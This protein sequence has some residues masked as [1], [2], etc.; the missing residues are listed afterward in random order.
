VAAALLAA[1]CGAADPDPQASEASSDAAALA[2]STATT[3]PLTFSSTTTEGEDFDAA[4]LAGEDVVLWFW[5]PWCTIC[6]S[7]APQVAAAAE[8]VDGVTVIGV[9]SSGSLEE[10]QAFVD[11]TGAGSITHVAGS[12][13]HVPSGLSTN[14][15]GQLYSPKLVIRVTNLS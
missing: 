13:T 11:E 3:N 14:R 9:A 2:S 1:G 6:R 4:D 8:Q 12:I 15:G 7:E 10:M 5:A